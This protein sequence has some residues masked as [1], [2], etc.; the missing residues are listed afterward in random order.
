MEELEKL[1]RG[2]VI[3]MPTDTIYGVVAQAL[4][5]SAVDRIYVIKG[6]DEHKP[7]IILLSDMHDLA[8]FGIVPTSA[9]EKVVSGVWP[10]PVSIILPCTDSRFSYL[11][12]GGE[13]LAFRVP[14]DESLR[15]I[16][17][18]VGPLVAPSAN[19]Q[20]F[21]PAKTIEEARSYFGSR[22]DGYV[23]GGLREGKA[24]RVISLR[25]DGFITQLRA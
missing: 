17:K 22:V 2:G 20:G 11:T 8:Q 25:E 23:N 6:R 18:E 5:S 4:V 16:L 12:R 14:A 10:G 19:P 24:S 1:T 9:Q 13:T 3:V 21:P 7:F 15:N